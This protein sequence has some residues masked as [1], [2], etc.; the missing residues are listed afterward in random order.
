MQVNKE[1]L[2]NLALAIND[3]EHRQDD[4][5]QDLLNTLKKDYKSLMR[6]FEEVPGPAMFDEYLLFTANRESYSLNECLLIERRLFM[7]L[8][9]K[10]EQLIKAGL[11]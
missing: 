4:S 5:K 9:P 3:L 8:R 6:Y 7:D 10:I 1:K 2:F 11:N